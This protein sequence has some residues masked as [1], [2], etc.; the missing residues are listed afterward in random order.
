MQPARFSDHVVGI[1]GVAFVLGEPD[2]SNTSFGLLV[3]DSEEDQVTSGGEAGVGEMAYRNGHRGGEVQHVDRP[4]TPNLAVDDLSAE[5]IVAPSVR[6]DRHDIGVAHEAQA[7]RRRI[8]ALDPCDHR[9]A[10]GRG[11]VGFEGQPWAFEGPD[12]R[13][14]VARLMPRIR[15]P[16]VDASVPNHRLKKLDRTLS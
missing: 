6:G 1:D 11:S 15:G 4:T 2:R 7:G 14:G 8:G 10:A 13:I 5:G 3:C 16:I 9:P 12:Q